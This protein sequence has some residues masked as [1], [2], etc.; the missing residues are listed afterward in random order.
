MTQID[1]WLRQ[2][3]ALND[4][5]KPDEAAEL[6]SRC[7]TLEPDN[8]KALY[9]IGS[10]MLKCGRNTQAQ[11]FLR[12]VC[13]LKPRD[14]RGWGQLS[15]SSAEMHRYDEAIEF[16]ERALSFK[17][18]SRTLANASFAH[19]TAGNWARGRSYALESLELEPGFKDALFHL[20]NC[21]LAQRRWADG[22][23]G[24]KVSEGGKWRKKWTYGD[25]KEWEGEADAVVMVT[26]EQGVGDEVLAAS[27]IPQAIKHCRK[28]IFDCHER[29]ASL[30]ARSFPD[31][32]VVPTR[33]KK[34]VA[35]PIAPTH[36]K[37]LFGL[38]SLFRRQDADFPRETFLRPNPQYVAMFRELFQSMGC[39]RV[40]GIGW[41]GGHPRTGLIERT[42]GVRSFLPLLRA[43]P[44]ATY[45][46]LQYKD[47]AA[48][49]LTLEL[50]TGAKVF[51]LPWVTQ[52][53]DMDVLAGLIAACDEVIGVA[54]AALHYSSAMGIPTTWLCNRGLIWTFAGDDLLWYPPTARIWRKD[55]V[56][57]WA[58]CINSL[59]QHRKDG[60]R[61]AA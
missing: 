33:E 23:A 17:R 53:Q 47:D 11:Q 6:A 9:L 20:A 26:G 25:T 42:A 48:E 28:F 29:N 44:D 31:A 24:F 58:Q 49:V 55:K 19:T 56:E 27:V 8:Y 54:T 3:D 36:H 14:H 52:G 40:V 18:D 5:D 45:V 13:E 35:L 51:R 15:I 60:R 10:V 22:W 1:E 12:R 21:D 16:A 30:F 2:A 7:L 43:E 38:L 61:A 50:E 39:K 34:Q 32:L 46:S 57:S 37:S 4:Q 59:A 41:S